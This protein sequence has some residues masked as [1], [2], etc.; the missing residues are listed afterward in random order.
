MKRK[1]P[2]H[3][4]TKASVGATEGPPKM[5]RRLLLSALHLI[6]RRLFSENFIVANLT[7]YDEIYRD[8]I[9]SVRHYLPLEDDSIQIGDEIL[10]V[11]RRRLPVPLVFVPPLA[12]TSMIF[13]LLPNR[14]LI[15]YFL[16]MGFD[17]YLLDWGEVTEAHYE[18]SLESYVLSWMP[19]AMKAVRE[20]S[21]Q[22]EVSCFCYCMGGLLTLMYAATANDTGLRN[23]VT[24]AS[25]IDMHQSG[26]AGQILSAVYRP[27]QI[28]SRLLNFSLMDLPARFMHVPGWLNSL[29][30]KL[31]NPLGSLINYWELLVNLWDRE[32]VINHTT[33]SRWFDDMVDYPGQ[34]IKEMTVS[35]MINNEM[36]GGRLKMGDQRAEFDNIRCAILA[37]AG[38]DDRLVSPRSAHRLLD[39]VASEDKE[40]CVVP[41]GHAGVFAGSQAPASTWAIAADW[42]VQRST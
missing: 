27:A 1:T 37:F 42:L 14:S 40:F 30:F 29:V 21:G 34:T 6:E 22:T 38:A 11:S 25:P 13:D 3:M 24:V 15:R 8:G 31:T 9:M 16:A 19:A 5:A 17:V 12:A 2:A 10:E 33:V 4:S 28:I 41:G 36:A 26:V 35:M 7:P 39:I 20:D 32:F 23:V 18:L